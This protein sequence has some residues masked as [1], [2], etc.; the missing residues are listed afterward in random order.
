M[1][2]AP[3]LTAGIVLVAGGLFFL[4]WLSHA[5]L[6][7]P[8]PPYAYALSKQAPAQ[9]FDELDLSSGTAGDLR[10]GRYE[11]RVEAVREPVAVAYVAD[12]PRLGKVLLEW[13]N[14][15]AEPVINDS[16]PAAQTATLAEALEEHAPEG[17]AVLSWWDTG[18][19]LRLLSRADV[20]FDQYL[21]KPLLLPEAW[22]G[23]EQRVADTEKAFW[24]VSA[25][26]PQTARFEAFVDALAAREAEGARK[27]R[28]LV[29]AGDAFLVLGQRDAFKLG[30]MRPEKFGIAYKDF[31]KGD[32]HGLAKNVKHWLVDNG[33]TAYSL[34]QLNDTTVRVFFLTDEATPNTLL[35]RLL[36]FTTSNPM[37][38]KSLD[39]VYQ[40]GE[41]WVYRVPPAPAKG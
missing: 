4:G 36:P 13:R 1:K 19:L 18:R 9:E 37:Q 7:P 27:L 29:G 21:G 20:T 8:P 41:Y 26:G 30:M 22:R 17:A 10:I 28:E 14:E 6:K 16:A 3:L 39:L 2:R 23:E 15:V 25:T 24:G 35:A 12:D 38:V 31:P 32:L 40:N 11:V 5:I 34:L 33:Y